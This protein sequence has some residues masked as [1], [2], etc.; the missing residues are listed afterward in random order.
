[1]TLALPRPE[2][3]V[4]HPAP[5]PTPDADRDEYRLL[6]VL[7]DAPRKDVDA[8]RAAG[9]LAPD[10]T[11][12]TLVQRFWLRRLERMTGVIRYVDW[13]GGGF[14]VTGLGETRWRAL[15]ARHAP[16]APERELA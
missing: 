16:P 15:H 6:S 12:P 2:V 4:P 10:A 13:A 9:L 11:E 14:V 3:P 7:F 8:L 5:A 1:M